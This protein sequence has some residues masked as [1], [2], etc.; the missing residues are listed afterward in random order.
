V[1]RGQISSAALRQIPAFRNFNESECH[2]LAE[3]AQEALFAPG[4][5]VLEQGKRSQNLWI[6]LEGKCE[7]IR[8]SP[9]DGPVVLA[10]M[11]PHSLFGEMSFFSPAPHSADVVAKT[12][13]KLLR[14][15]RGDYDDLICEG[16]PV[17]YKLAYNIVESVASR[18]RRMDEWIAELA[19]EHGIHAPPHSEKQP[20]WQ[21]FREKLFNGWNL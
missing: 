7:V 8:E 6:V 20:E 2:Q 21:Q 13:L 14:I 19:S 9:D 16:V 11:G 3:I 12:P 18:L 15:E 5:K 17:A 4:D 1:I 10:E